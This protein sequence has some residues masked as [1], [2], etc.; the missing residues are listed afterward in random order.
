M[1]ASFIAGA[2]GWHATDEGFASKKLLSRRL[3]W[4]ASLTSE[5]DRIISRL[6]S[7]VD[8]RWYCGRNLIRV[9]AKVTVGGSQQTLH[10]EANTPEKQPTLKNPSLLSLV[11]C[12][13]CFIFVVSGCLIA[14]EV[15]EKNRGAASLLCI[16]LY[17][18]IEKEEK[19]TIICCLPPR[20][21]ALSSL[22]S[23][24]KIPHYFKSRKIRFSGI[25]K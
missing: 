15:C 2:G 9:V 18:L 21:D 22:R 23:L 11:F 17:S 20:N 14:N 13:A 1:G 16:F 24:Q 5:S 19:I 4:S 25:P 7:W 12:G 3:E 6:R 8:A 10:C